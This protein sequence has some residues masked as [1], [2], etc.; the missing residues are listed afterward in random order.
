MHT[1]PH[2][3]RN[4]TDHETFFFRGTLVDDVDLSRL[5][6][7]CHGSITL[8]LLTVWVIFS[9]VWFTPVL[10]WPGLQEP[11]VLLIWESSD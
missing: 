11:K 5:K 1:V 6:V 10:A 9:C 8:V 3:M 2:A 7:P 4:L